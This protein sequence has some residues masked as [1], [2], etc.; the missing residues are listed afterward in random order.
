MDI[1]LLLL[2]LMTVLLLLASGVGL[3]RLPLWLQRVSS[4][5]RNH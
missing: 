2:E 3:S 5:G 1:S 4:S